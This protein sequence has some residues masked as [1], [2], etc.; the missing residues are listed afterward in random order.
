MFF[1]PPVEP[2]VR[3]FRT[4][5]TFKGLLWL[6]DGARAWMQTAGAD[7]WL[8]FSWGWMCSQQ[9][10]NITY[11]T[12]KAE[13]E[14]EAHRHSQNIYHWPTAAELHSRPTQTSTKLSPPQLCCKM[15][16]CQ[17]Y[18]NSYDQQNRWSHTPWQDGGNARIQTNSSSIQTHF[19]IFKI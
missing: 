13:E 8:P 19:N 17:I 18:L 6:M 9:K 10:N 12:Q 7:L 5:R 11:P 14:P 15:S 1:L 16:S 2:G 4:F 3:F